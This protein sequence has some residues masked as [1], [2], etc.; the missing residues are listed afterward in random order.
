MFA[1]NAMAGYR[2]IVA[3]PGYRE[4]VGRGRLD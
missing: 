3:L 2:D 1:S 4:A